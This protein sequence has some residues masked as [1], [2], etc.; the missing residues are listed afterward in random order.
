MWGLLCS[1]LQEI[2]L[3]E[4]NLCGLRL[5]EDKE[6]DTREIINRCTTSE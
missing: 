4:C 1:G 6:K 5:S 3:G 2:M